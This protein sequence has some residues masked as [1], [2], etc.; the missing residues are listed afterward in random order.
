M[1]GSL[2]VVGTGPGKAELMTPAT[3]SGCSPA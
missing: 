2:V 3:R 1:N